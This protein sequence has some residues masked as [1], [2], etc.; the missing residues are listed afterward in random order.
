M[1]FFERPFTMVAINGKSL[2]AWAQEGRDAVIREAAE[3]GLITINDRALAERLGV[4]SGTVTVS[5]SQSL[6]EVT[7]RGVWVPA[8]KPKKKRG[9]R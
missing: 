2:D 3:R 7:R 8:D 4:P 9:A 6:P 5:H 1:S